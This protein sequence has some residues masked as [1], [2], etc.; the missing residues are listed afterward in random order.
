MV[1]WD[2]ACPTL[3]T[4]AI[5]MKCFSVHFDF[6]RQRHELCSLWFYMAS[7][8]V[9]KLTIK[10]QQAKYCM[11]FYYIHRLTYF[12]LWGVNFAAPGMHC[13]MYHP[14]ILDYSYKLQDILQLLIHVACMVM[15]DGACPT[16]FTTAIPTSFWFLRNPFLLLVNSLAAG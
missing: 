12:L 4:T 15:W 1:M 9:Y 14:Y 11:R 10:Y 13:P 16:L 6:T 3:F 7:R 2:G 8:W 5:P